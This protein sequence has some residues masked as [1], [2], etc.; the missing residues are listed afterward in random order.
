ML[1]ISDPATANISLLTSDQITFSDNVVCDQPNEREEPP[2]PSV[3]KIS[4][5]VG[6]LL[7]GEHSG[8]FHFALPN[9]LLYL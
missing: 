4:D 3:L 5:I 2:A 7:K 6:I 1:S 9:A 8:K